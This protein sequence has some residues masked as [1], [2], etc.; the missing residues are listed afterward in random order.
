MN[1]PLPA[2]SSAR[3]SALRVKSEN[4]ILPTSGPSTNAST[5]PI[6]AM[7]KTTP[8][9]RTTP[10]RNSSWRSEPASP[11]SFGSSVPCTAWNASTGTRETK[12]AD[13]KA[14][15]TSFSDGDERRLMASSGEYASSWVSTEPRRSQPSEADSSQYGA[16]GPGCSRPRCR[17]R[18]TATAKNGAMASTS[19]YPPARLTPMTARTMP[20]ARRITPSAP[21]SS[22]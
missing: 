22:P 17:R 14:A 19:A 2:A 11:A 10:L 6:T 9:S 15:A 20:T 8:R 5:V 3:P 7:A 21:S 12:N 18:A 4:R 1:A 16:S 13:A